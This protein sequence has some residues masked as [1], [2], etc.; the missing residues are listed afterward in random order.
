MPRK[1]T[2]LSVGFFARICACRRSDAEPMTLPSLR[3]ERLV[4]DGEMNTYK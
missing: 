3:P 4:A 1:L 2:H